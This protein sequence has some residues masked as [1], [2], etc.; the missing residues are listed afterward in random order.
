MYDGFEISCNSQLHDKLTF[1]FTS[2]TNGVE[3]LVQEGP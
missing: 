3:T 2:R 1:Q